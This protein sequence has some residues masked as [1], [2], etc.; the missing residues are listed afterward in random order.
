MPNSPKTLL[1][2]ALYPE[3]KPIIHSFNLIQN[4]LYEPL[5]VFE[6]DDYIL[7]V[8]GIG[9]D[10]TKQCLPTV[11]ENFNIS[12]AVNVGIAGC[13]DTRVKLGSLFCTNQTL[14]GIEKG[15]ITCVNTPLD[16]ATKLDTL[17]VD[18]ESDAFLEISRN[19][20]K[21]NNIFV[22]KIVSDYLDTKI[23]DK[24][25]VY[26]SIKKSIAKWVIML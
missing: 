14:E 19:Y 9:K 5:K 17:L 12:K 2:T 13:K 7:V 4:K 21:D 8:G 23:P 1:H 20:L 3:A 24:S 6:N 25:F 15:S 16:D 18:M 26:N 10:K 11:Y 22:F